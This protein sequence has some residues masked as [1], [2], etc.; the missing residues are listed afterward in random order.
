VDPFLD[1]PAVVLVLLSLA[2]TLFVI[3]VALPTAGVA[4]TLALLLGAAALVG[5]D[6][7]D[8]EWWPLLG[9]M[10]AVVLWAVLVARRQ[11]STALEPI[12]LVLF[13]AGSAGFGLLAESP[14]TVAVGLAITVALG[15]GYPALHRAAMRLLERPAQ[16]G[17]EA[18]VGRVGVVTE[19]DGPHGSVRLQ[20]SLW[21]ATSSARLT[22]GDEVEVQAFSGMTIT[23]S[24]RVHPQVPG[25]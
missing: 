25:A 8:A 11:R 12:A 16:V 17:M 14:A 23:V 13:G 21:T 9:P 5:I 2:A 1:Q 19:W 24:P 20:G 10:T 4:G 18:L 7:Q 15:A 3:E 22:V 6:R